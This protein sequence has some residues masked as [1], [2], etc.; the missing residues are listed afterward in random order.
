MPSD[1]TGTDIIEEDAGQRAPRVAV[2]PRSGLR[3]CRSWPTRSTARRRRPRRRCSRRCRSTR[4]PPAERRYPLEEPF[5]VLATQNPIE[6]EGTYPL[7]EAQLD[8]FVNEFVSW[9]AGPRASQYLVLASKARA[10]LDGRFAASIEDIQALA[11]PTLQ[12]RLILNYRAEAEG[13]RAGTI[14][15]RLLAAIPT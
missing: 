5:F 3:Q 15:E 1:I 8:R 14:V 4:S 13:E 9:G 10:I 12:H 11:K 6:Q 7:P 2:R